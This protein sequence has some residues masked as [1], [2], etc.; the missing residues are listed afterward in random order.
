[1]KLKRLEA[2]ETPYGRWKE[3]SSRFANMHN[4]KVRNGPTLLDASS[5]KGKYFL[6]I[7][8]IINYDRDKRASY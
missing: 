1:M 7:C 4:Q 2:N 3:V 8:R 6:S 5:I